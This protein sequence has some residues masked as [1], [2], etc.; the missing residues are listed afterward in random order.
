MSYQRSPEEIA[1]IKAHLCDVIADGTLMTVA[2][3]ELGVS[4]REL[5]RWKREDPEFR[6]NLEDANEW[7]TERKADELAT[8]HETVLDAK[9]A[10]VAVNSLKWWLA[11]RNPRTF[12]DKIETT[13]DQP[14]L[15]SILNAAIE[16]AL[17]DT[18]A[19][20]DVTP[21]VEKTS[22]VQPNGRA[23]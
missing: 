11:K 7:L 4:Y 19:V 15:I 13:D 14:H 16:R 10:Q 21:V 18:R 1:V 23:G 22:G 3:Q 5:Y 8:I 12:G 17:R 9:R 20:V 2:C 6:S